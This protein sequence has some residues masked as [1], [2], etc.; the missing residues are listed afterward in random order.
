MIALTML[1]FLLG[2]LFLGI[3]I[4]ILLKPSGYFTAQRVLTC[5]ETRNPARVRVDVGHRLRT[6][7]WGREKLRLQSCSRWPGRQE[8]GEECLL[9]VDLNP[10]VLDRA[11]RAWAEGKA[12]AL[13]GRRLREADWR[14]GHFSGL[15][16]RSA[17]IPPTAMPLHELPMALQHYRPVCWPCHLAQGRQRDPILLKGDRRVPREPSWTGT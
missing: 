16:D 7:L 15:N 9:Q 2:A 14:M 4:M 17:W 5:P 13:C 8:C 3:C 12:C 10:E 11:L 6:A 1:L